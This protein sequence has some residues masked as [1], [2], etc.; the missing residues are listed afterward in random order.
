ME[1]VVT[2][3]QDSILAK[4]DVGYINVTVADKAALCNP[5]KNLPITVEVEGGV[6][7]GMGS[8]QPDSNE[9]YTGNTCVT[10]E[11]RALV[12]VRGF[13]T[14]VLTA[15]VSAEGYETKTVQIEVK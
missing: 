6:I 9:N 4:T 3:E 14:G 10:F 12:V 7:A 5:A 15:K 2:A 8:G 13:E 11:G 1:L